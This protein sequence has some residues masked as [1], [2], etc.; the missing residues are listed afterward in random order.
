VVLTAA[1]ALEAE[2]TASA[3]AMVVVFLTAGMTVECS[4]FNWLPKLLLR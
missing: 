3:T 2:V 4:K 1:K